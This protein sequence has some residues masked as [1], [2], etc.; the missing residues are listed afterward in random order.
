MITK[1]GVDLTHEDMKGIGAGVGAGLGMNMLRE[2]EAQNLM[3][4]FF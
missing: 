3:N 1:L 2:R 4:T